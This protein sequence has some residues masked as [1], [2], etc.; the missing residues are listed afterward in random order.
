MKIRE[1][2]RESLMEALA[3]LGVEEPAGLVVERPRLKEHGDLSTP[4]AFVLAKKCGR[5]PMEV[6]AE[7]LAAV[8]FPAEVVAKVEVAEPG[9]I[10]LTLADAALRANL[11][12][13]LAQGERYGSAPPTGTRY[14]VE[15]V[16][17]NPTGP[18]VV[19]SARAAAFG[20]ALVNLL[21]FVGHQVEAEY[22]VNDHGRQVETLGESLR[23]RLKEAKGLLPAGETIG[24]YPGEYLREVARS[25][26]DGEVERLLR[27][28]SVELGRLATDRIL[29]WIKRDLRDF[30]VNFH[31]FFRESSLHPH[32]LS[33]ALSCLEQA[34]GTYERDGAL[35]FRSTNFGDEKDRVLKKSSG[36]ATYFLGDVAYHLDKLRRGYRR[37]IDIWGPDHHGH[38]KRMQ[39]ACRVLGAPE[40]WLEVLIVGWVRLVEEGK[41][42]AMSKR[43]GEFVSMRELLDDV[44]SDVTKYFFLM[45]RAHSPLDFDLALA[46]KQSEENPVF[47]VQYAHARIASVIR[48]ARSRGVTWKREAG[49]LGGLELLQERDLMLQLMFF[50][51]VVEGAATTREPHRLTVYAQELATLFHQF[52]QKCRIVSDDPALSGARLVLVEATKQV[53]GN[54]L[55]LLGVSAP[56]SM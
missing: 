47:Y 55:R 35:Y 31:R 40:D 51:Y 33:Q 5:R 19:V 52:Y 18:L 25:V 36:E 32:G 10:N 28:S 22:Y 24:A 54:T 3:R 27:A 43:A 9:F 2:I 42:V 1:A 14:Q 29:E 15:Y 50:P 53:L 46:R 20:S 30:G 7:V 11:L 48:Y 23:F 17:A 26:P 37:V 4:L 45:R 12:E 39:A 38:V 8:D 21:S 13:V 44:G 16:S 56:E 41:P 6:A 34:G 49:S